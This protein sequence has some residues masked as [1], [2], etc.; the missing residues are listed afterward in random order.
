METIDYVRIAFRKL[1]AS[2]YFDK[3][4]LPLRDKV[5]EFETN[6]D[7]E[8][9]LNEIAAAY[10]NEKLKK[11]STLM[12]KILSS[13][14]V[15]SFPKKLKKEEKAIINVSNPRERSLLKE[16][17]YFIDM[18]VCGHILGIIWIMKFGK[19][20][21]EKCYQNAHANR[22]R[23]AHI[24]E[25]ES[26]EPKD[27]PALFEPYFG[28]YSLWRD[29]GLSCAE[30]LLDKK[31]DTLI[32]TLDLKSFYYSTGITENVFNEIINEF[33]DSEDKNMNSKNELLH[34]AIFAIIERYSNILC[35]E[36]KEL[37][38]NVL[39]IG[40]LPSAVLANWCLLKFDKGILD[41]W[42]PAYYGRYVDDIIIVDKVEKGSEIYIKARDDKLTQE[43]VIEYYL[44]DGRRKDTSR[45]VERVNSCTEETLSDGDTV[46][47]H[48]SK[49][50]QAEEEADKAKSNE[51]DV[52]IIKYTVNK[53]FCL[54]EQ[55][56]FE[57]QADKTRIFTL[58]AEN[59]STALIRKFRQE[60]FKNISDFRLMPEFGKA[61]SQ[62]DFSKFYKLD[63][64]A[65][66]NKFRGVKSI[67]LDKYEL[68]KFLGS[69]RVV[70]SL[71]EDVGTKKFTDTI[72]KMF[73]DP[74][75]VE[76]YIFWERVL[77]IFIT[78]KD[79][80]GFIKFVKKIKSAIGALKAE[81]A[82]EINVDKIKNSL[83]KHLTAALNRVLSLLWGANVE[84]IM[85]AIYDDEMHPQLR[86]KYLATHMSNKYVMAIPADEL[87]LVRNMKE[88]YPTDAD[89]VNFTDFAD[90][91]KYL[92]NKKVRI[93][94]DET[95]LPHFRRAQDIAISM[96]L[97]SICNSDIR[98]N[99][100][101]EYIKSI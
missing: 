2:V 25:E 35:K 86:Y 31:H 17:Q 53:A 60:I 68:S 49:E 21:D 51:K 26:D 57:F 100:Y 59:N 15:L 52:E 70:S 30:E 3:T 8:E 91:F 11:D 24:W 12:K 98:D 20:L 65:T 47:S 9:K 23:T 28:Q 29:G 16:A 92:C 69:Y 54:S 40:F 80:D 42:N 5:V 55:S 18:D 93:S 79:Y 58:F 85:K 71:V 76:N 96:L 6:S 95:S 37:S 44:G 43:N 75:L 101:D 84:K 90:C 7:F 56:N 64:D 22:L 13:I 63:N 45:F 10:D 48:N 81:G 32:L 73:N 38:P 87:C 77:E 4:I 72:G 99:T 61:F 27:T 62:N 46:K 50:T 67:L 36:K 83:R 34:S 41:F 88:E 66:I 39:P 78:D 33:S 19:K 1:K 14:G 89:M 97:E 74:E 94:P 82:V